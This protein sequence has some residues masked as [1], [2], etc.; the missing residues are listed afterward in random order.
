MT[1]FPP[2]P[3]G[4]V[5]PAGLSPHGDQLTADLNALITSPV[6]FLATGVFARLRQASAG[7]S[8]TPAAH[9]VLAYD[10]VDEDP[11]GGWSATATAS[12]PAHSWLCPAGCSGWYL[13]TV[14]A[15]LATPPSDSALRPEILLN[16]SPWLALAGPGA[17][18]STNSQG[19]GSGY[20]YLLGGSDYVQGGAFLATGSG[21]QLTSVAAGFQ[22]LLQVS[23][24]S[25]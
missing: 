6:S 10:T 25:N 4:P 2:P 17:T 21:A 9:N 14:T 23:W 22:P 20:V 12:Q 16:G 1:L 24:E 7:Q 5:L 13:A 11:Y 19:D 3:G 18:A 8:L 15:S